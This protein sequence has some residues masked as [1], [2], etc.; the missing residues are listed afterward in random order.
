MRFNEVLNDRQ[1]QSHAAVD[2]SSGC[3]P[4]PEFLKN[5]WKKFRS[6]SNARIHHADFHVTGDLRKFNQDTAVIWREFHSICKKIP[7]HLLQPIRIS[8]NDTADR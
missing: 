6:D 7:E 1:S 3:I 5:M 8:G 4:L 2:A